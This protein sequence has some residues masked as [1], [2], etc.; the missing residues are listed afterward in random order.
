MQRA[1]KKS[2]HI[3]RRRRGPQSNTLKIVED[4]IKNSA[5]YPTRHQIWRKLSE[6]ISE[7]EFKHALARLLQDNKIMYDK[8]DT[9]IWTHIDDEKREMLKGFTVIN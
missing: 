4:S 2:R 5:S 7:M 9:I 8:D 3:V 1:L 6:S